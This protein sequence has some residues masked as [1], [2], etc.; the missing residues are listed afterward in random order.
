MIL[1]LLF[2]VTTLGSTVAVPK[3]NAI[4]PGRRDST[5][6][7]IPQYSKISR[8]HSGRVSLIENW[9]SDFDAYRDDDHEALVAL[10]EAGFV[11]G[12]MQAIDEERAAAG[13]STK[14]PEHHSIPFSES[15]LIMGFP[16]TYERKESTLCVVSFLGGFILICVAVAFVV[17][18]PWGHQNYSPSSTHMP[19]LEKDSLVT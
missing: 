6:R 19:A 9:K 8:L 14:S 4:Q 5:E 11:S 17:A 10:C 1:Y 18:V 15:T 12:C 2:S 16:T 3:S 7:D 13:P